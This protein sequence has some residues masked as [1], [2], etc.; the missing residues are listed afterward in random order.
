[1]IEDGCDPISRLLKL[2]RSRGLKF[3]HNRVRHIVDSAGVCTEL[4]VRKCLVENS[5]LFSGLNETNSASGHEQ[6]RLESTFIRND[7]HLQTA[8]IRKLTG[9]RLH[10]GDM[11]GCWGSNY[12]RSASADLGNSLL[13]RGQLI[14]QALDFTCHDGWKLLERVL[15]FSAL[16][17]FCEIGR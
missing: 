14:S 3:G 17:L 5:H 2:N 13:G 8:W 16:V 12:V 9:G 4:L 15:R 6:L 1:M 10:R 11:S 7:L